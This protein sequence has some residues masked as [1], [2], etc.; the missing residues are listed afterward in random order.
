M[1][2]RSRA[3]SSVKLNS[4]CK[5]ITVVDLSQTVAFVLSCH[6]HHSDSYMCLARQTPFHETDPE[7]SRSCTP[8]VSQKCTVIVATC[9]HQ[10]MPFTTCHA[11]NS[12]LFT[13]DM[14]CLQTCICAVCLCCS[15]HAAIWKSISACNDTD[16]ID[17]DPVE[18]CSN[19]HQMELKLPAK[20][21]KSGCQAV[22]RLTDSKHNRQP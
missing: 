3:C 7:C 20:H 5:H 22:R 17:A 6:D 16:Q 2:M 13:N 4:S 8:H 11:T 12:Q 18:V 10:Q 9:V 1:Q 21:F 15:R 19:M 14:L